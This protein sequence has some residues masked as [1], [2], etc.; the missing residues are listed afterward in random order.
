VLRSKLEIC[1]DKIVELT[2]L[3]IDEQIKNLPIKVNRAFA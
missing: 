3:Q 2:K 1:E